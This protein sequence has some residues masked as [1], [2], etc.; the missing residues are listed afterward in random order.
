MLD[1]LLK[2]DSI[3]RRMG[4]GGGSST[5]K[6]V[7]ALKS[8]KRR[9]FRKSLNKALDPFLDECLKT[10]LVG[11]KGN[12]L[13]ERASVIVSHLEELDGILG[14]LVIERKIAEELTTAQYEILVQLSDMIHSVVE[15]R[16]SMD[17][18]LKTYE[19]H[20]PE[21]LFLHKF[22]TSLDIERARQ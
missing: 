7:V 10:Y 16:G 14:D 9:N 3:V 12:E 15:E 18:M 4:I 13:R 5:I 17:R 19:D 1:V 8:N 6:N 22:L 21:K 20:F 2:A 11:V